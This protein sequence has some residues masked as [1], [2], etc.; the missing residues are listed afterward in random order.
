MEIFLLNI[1]DFFHLRKELEFIMKFD[2]VDILKLYLNK[3]YIFYIK[4]LEGNSILIKAK[5]DNFKIFKI[6]ETF[7]V[8]SPISVKHKLKN[9][10]KFISSSEKTTNLINNFGFKVLLANEFLKINVENNIFSNANFQQF[11]FEKLDINTNAHIR[12]E[13]QNEVF[14]KEDRCPLRVK[15]VKYECLK[16]CFIPELSYFIKLDSKYLGYGQILYLDDKYTVV[17]LCI[18]KEYQNKGYGKVLLNYLLYKAKEFG[19][20]KVFIKV[21]SANH[22]AKKLYKKVGFELV[23][24]NSVLEA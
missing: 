8:Y 11:E 24:V 20:S 6:F 9:N 21:S 16:K 19:L 4:N 7:E 22:N 13:I 23:D 10:Y 1:L 17:N 12:C 3:T 2:F 14:E 5:K 15:D 18:R